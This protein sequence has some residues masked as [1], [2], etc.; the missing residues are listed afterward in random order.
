M[1]CLEL[2]LLDL[3]KRNLNRSYWNLLILY[4]L[5]N[6]LIPS[7]AVHASPLPEVNAYILTS[8]PPM[9]CLAIRQTLDHALRALKFVFRQNSRKVNNSLWFLITIDYSYWATDG[10]VYGDCC[11]QLF[12]QQNCCIGRVQL[13]ATLGCTPCNVTLCHALLQSVLT[14]IVQSHFVTPFFALHCNLLQHSS[15]SHTLQRFVTLQCNTL[16]RFVALH[17]KLLQHSSSVQSNPLQFHCTLSDISLQSRFS[18]SIHFPNQS[19]K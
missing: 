16:S 6:H 18:G 5:W 9:F 14:F 17:C 8:H 2:V 1:D 4:F 11:S 19:G 13:V 12:G 7:I 3:K 10:N 15:Y